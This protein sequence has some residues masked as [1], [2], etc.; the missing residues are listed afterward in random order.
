[1]LTLFK[2]SI[3]VAFLLLGGCA[4]MNQSECLNA[5]WQMIGLEDGSRGRTLAHIGNHRKACAE[6]NISPDLESYQRGHAQGLQQYC[7]YDKGFQLGSRG[8]AFRNICP[9]ELEED[10]RVGHQRGRE[11]HALNMELKRTQTAIKEMYT[12]LDELSAE[13]LDKEDL[14]ISRKTREL[15]RALLLL[16]VKEIQT[17]IGRLEVEV[18][19]LEQQKSDIAYERNLLKQRYQAGPG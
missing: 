19:L 5:D 1:M 10:F 6:F 17:E 4:T 3:V 7:T 2:K 15:E 9:P 14:I 18:E 11:I 12:L 13:A 16:D 8:N